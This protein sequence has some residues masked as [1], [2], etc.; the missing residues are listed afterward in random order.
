[1]VLV[2]R[3][4]KKKRKDVCVVEGRKLHG[5]GWGGQKSSLVEI[6]GPPI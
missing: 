4:G 3:E 2:V 1:M 5:G 6:I